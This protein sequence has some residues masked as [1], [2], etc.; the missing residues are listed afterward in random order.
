MR[1][2]LVAPV[3]SRGRARTPIGRPVA[4]HFAAGIGAG[5]APVGRRLVLDG[6]PAGIVAALR[7]RGRSSS[8]SRSGPSARDGIHP[9][10]RSTSPSATGCSRS[11]SSAS[12]SSRRRPRS[13]RRSPMR[14]HRPAHRGR[15]GCAPPG[16]LAVVGVLQGAAGHRPL[17]VTTLDDRLGV[18]ALRGVRVPRRARRRAP[19]GRRWRGGPRARAG[20]DGRPVGRRADE[21]RAARDRDAPSRV[22]GRGRGVD[23]GLGGLCRS[24]SRLPRPRSACRSRC[25]RSGSWSPWSSG[26][27]SRDCSSEPRSRRSR[28]SMGPPSGPLT[29]RERYIDGFLGLDGPAC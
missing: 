7:A 8:R 13:R 5:P 28:T 26:T 29:R 23:L 10:I 12:A 20:P 14:R 9:G 6:G 3:A 27:A 24:R 16:V 18:R 17:P 15:A 4:L 21:H 19:G 1:L 11:S 2:S 25:W 22:G